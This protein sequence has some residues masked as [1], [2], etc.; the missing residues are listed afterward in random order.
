MGMTTDLFNKCFKAFPDAKGSLR[1]G[2][3]NG[4]VIA[5]VH[6]G[7]ITRARV[8]TDQGTVNIAQGT[9]KYLK[10]DED[11]TVAFGDVVELRSS[12]ALD[13]ERVRI[14]GRRDVAGLVTLTLESEFA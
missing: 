1:I 6:T 4:I 7:G 5:G 2:G 8:S 13:Y 9:A 12:N 10:A 14:M 3:V 11:K